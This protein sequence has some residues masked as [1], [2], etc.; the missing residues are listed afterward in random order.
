M[1]KRKKKQEEPLKLDMSFEE[2][3]KLM[4]TIPKPNKDKNAPLPKIAPPKKKDK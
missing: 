2:A 3:V 1:V 4:L